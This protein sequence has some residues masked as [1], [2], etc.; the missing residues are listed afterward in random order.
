MSISAEDARIKRDQKNKER[1][2]SESLVRRMT[3]VKIID[4][5]IQSYIDKCSMD[6]VEHQFNH[7][8]LDYIKYYY[9]RLGYKV[10]E[11]TPE[12]ILGFDKQAKVKISF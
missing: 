11:T 4:N 8:D 9:E 3:L 6:S 10:E 12:P 7:I 2:D 1:T 5:R